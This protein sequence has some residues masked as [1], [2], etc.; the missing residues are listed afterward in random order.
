MLLLQKQDTQYN[1]SIKRL[2]SFQM[3]PW[4]L[5][6]EKQFS[7][8]TV[9]PPTIMPTFCEYLIIVCSLAGT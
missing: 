6:G 4:S 2:T 9:A 1:Q 7:P 3:L 5:K 8:E